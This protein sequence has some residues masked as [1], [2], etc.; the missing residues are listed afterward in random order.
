MPTNDIASY[1]FLPWLRQG[2]TSG[3]GNKDNFNPELDE[4]EE[5]GTVPDIR[6]S[7]TMD[8]KF[9]GTPM[10]SGA[11][12]EFDKTKDVKL[13][14][15]FDILGI[16]QDAIV[17]TDPKNWI[18]NFEP[19]YLPY[20][21][22]YDEDFLWR[23]TPAAPFGTEL[24]NQ[25]LRPWITL[26]VLKEDEFER[27]PFN[28]VNPSF[29]ILKEAVEIFPDQ[30]QLF[31]WGHVHVNEALTGSV[32]E[33][34]NQLDNILKTDPNKAVSRLLCPRR[35]DDNTSYYAFVIPTFE[36]GRLAGL[37]L[38]IPTSAP[39]P[40]AL[41]PA[42]A[43]ADDDKE[44]P[45]YYEW[46]FK[47]GSVGNFEYLVELL[48]P[49]PL[50][51]E[52]VG[53][54]SLDIQNP[55]LLNLKGK[56]VN[57]EI[58]LYGAVKPIESPTPVDVW[59]IP[60]PPASPPPPTPR[61]H[62]FIDKFIEI[63]NS[64]YDGTLSLP[65]PDAD[66]EI[67]PPIYGRWHAKKDHLDNLSDDWLHK[68]N[69]DPSYRVFAGVGSQVVKKRQEEFMN[70][71]WKQVAKIEE[72]NKIIRQL[73]LAK[74]ASASIFKR[75]FAAAPADELISFTNT[76]HP[77][78][79]VSTEKTLFKKTQESV[80]PQGC[81]TGAF[82][83]ITRPNGFVAKNTGTT[84]QL[85]ST[86]KVINSINSGTTSVAKTYPAP[87]GMSAYTILPSSSITSTYTLGLP[88]RPTFYLTKPGSTYYSPGSGGIAS[89]AAASY[90][91]VVPNVHNRL[92]APSTAPPTGDALVLSGIKTN[93]TENIDPGNTMLNI[94]KK[95]VVQHDVNGQI[96]TLD[97][98]DLIL[99]APKIEIA[100]YKDLYDISPDLLMPKLNDLPANSISILE[101]NQKVIEAYM[102]GLNHEMASELLWREFPTDQRGT[103]FM[104]FWESYLTTHE[105]TSGTNYDKTRSI[106]P[107]HQWKNTAG[108]A[109]SKLGENRPSGYPTDLLLLTVRGE[110]LKK[111]PNALIYA[112]KA[113]WG[114]NT[115]QVDDVTQP[116]AM[117][118]YNVTNGDTK[119]PLFT[120]R[121]SDVVF[122]GFALTAVEAVGT[123]VEATSPDMTKPGWF[124]VFEEIGGEIHFGLDEF[125]EENPI[126]SIT[127]PLANWDILNWGHM[128]GSVEDIKFINTSRDINIVST[129]NLSF[130]D[131]GS[132]AADMAYA[133]Y[134][135]PSLLAVHAKDLLEI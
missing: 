31:A 52:N 104:R 107:I 10:E 90:V 38:G 132:N 134:R 125:D 3:I 72:A 64:P 65:N 133:L 20:I 69:L 87:A 23:Y 109:L 44:F 82:R 118:A 35:L 105:D 17:R 53:K 96:V 128:G 62:Q 98:L 19:N 88:S 46:F 119:L 33:G 6:V 80:I 18:T 7:I 110:L 99:E 58:P 28:G 78:I 103:V 74:E 100:M 9:K 55:G 49:T 95:L 77:R 131:W 43:N 56:A 40:N 124:F 57:K 122:I 4:E 123:D 42:W 63:L 34:V 76:V 5:I 39:I 16:S 91:G 86:A 129:A 11:D 106:K 36:L 113:K 94:A 117:K 54:R 41:T 30:Q 2:L 108:T 60:Y 102:M 115:S 89:A 93:I 37:G 84:S 127:N 116:R 135:S 27:M 12:V 85:I 126:L 68:T 120:A 67:A 79:V 130:I 29:K 32:S 26:V 112:N 61:E 114:Q 24:R 51:I 59:P 15:P 8:I 50:T 47:T 70:L 13:Y 1:S 22:F 71:A 21:E 81:F 121:V 111:Y 75:T 101:P 66:P 25:K 83:K 45:I 48:Q 73:Q 92:S 97:N 14:G